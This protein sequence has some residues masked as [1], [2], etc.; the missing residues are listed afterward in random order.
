ML[1]KLSIIALL[2]LVIIPAGVMAAGYQAKGGSSTI[3]A[4]GQQS[5]GSQVIGQYRFSS[6]N[7]FEITTDKGN[8][9]LTRNRTCEQLQNGTQGNSPIQGELQAGSGTMDPLQ[10]QNHTRNQQQRCNM[11]S[12]Q[13]KNMTRS[14]LTDGSCGNC[15]RPGTTV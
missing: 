7:G 14:R 12:E 1:K 8:G 9:A 6:Q 15:P 2:I 11:T 13:L 4:G 3:S 5:D 10:T